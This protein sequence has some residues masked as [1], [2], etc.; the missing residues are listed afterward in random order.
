MFFDGGGERRGRG[1]LLG[2]RGWPQGWI[3]IAVWYTTSP[4]SDLEFSSADP[5]ELTFS[6]M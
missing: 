2:T 6:S 1:L 4:F 5:E 3:Y